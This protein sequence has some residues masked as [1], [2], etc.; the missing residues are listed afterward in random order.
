MQ[1][2]DTL[3]FRRNLMGYVEESCVS[4]YHEWVRGVQFFVVHPHHNETDEP[5]DAQRY[6]MYMLN[7]HSVCEFMKVFR[8]SWI[9]GEELPMPDD[10][11]WHTR[12][13]VY[14]SAYTP[15]TEDIDDEYTYRLVVR[16]RHWKFFGDVFVV[17]SL[18]YYSE[19]PALRD[20]RGV[21]QTRAMLFPLTQAKLAAACLTCINIESMWCSTNHKLFDH[22][23]LIIQRAPKD[24]KLA[25]VI[26]EQYW[27]DFHKEEFIGHEYVLKFN[28]DFTDA[29]ITKAN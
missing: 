7:Y 10:V 1:L 17:G 13:A 27:A 26:E 20:L 16:E 25:G 15:K 21:S 12:E 14:F 4:I 5:W 22:P 2:L 18:K 11:I 3:R 8:E 23:E 19:H 9:T 29:I 24:R 28:G 6:A